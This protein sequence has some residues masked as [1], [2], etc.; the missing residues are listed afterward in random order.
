MNARLAQ[1]N[2]LIK[3]TFAH[4]SSKAFLAIDEM[5]AGQSCRAVPA[6]LANPPPERGDVA[7]SSGGNSAEINAGSAGRF[8]AQPSPWP[9][10]CKTRPRAQPLKQAN[11]ARLANKLNRSLVFA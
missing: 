11:L 4:I 8:G 10:N 1:Q 9:R 2:P 6:P 7:S 3:E 5:V